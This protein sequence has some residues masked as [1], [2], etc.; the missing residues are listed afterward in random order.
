MRSGQCL[1]CK[2][3]TLL[4]TDLCQICEESYEVERD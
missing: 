4:V 3:L 1:G 2:R